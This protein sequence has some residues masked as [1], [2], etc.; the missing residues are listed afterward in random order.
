MAPAE[1][2]TVIKSGS[3]VMGAASWQGNL[4]KF[5]SKWMDMLIKSYLF[6]ALILFGY[7]IPASA[8][9]INCPS[10]FASSG[11]CL[12]GVTAGA[13][14][15]SGIGLGRVEVDATMY[16]DNYQPA[17]A[18]TFKGSC[19]STTTTSCTITGGSALDPNGG[20]VWA[21]VGDGSSDG[22]WI[23]YSSANSTTITFATSGRGYWGSTAA[24]HGNGVDLFLYIAPVYT[25]ITSATAK[26]TSGTIT[27]TACGTTY[28]SDI[29]LLTNPGTTN[30]ISVQLYALTSSGSGTLTIEP[31]T[32]C[33]SWQ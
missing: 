31:G 12:V 18:A 26:A 4:S 25:T 27:P 16:V 3:R 9:V 14:T 11:C 29:W 22:E 7:L 28:A 21:C 32:G 15:G 24:T 6:W 23:K 1:A 33:G 5:K 17:G 2:Q 8:Q 10:G 30:N 19:A 13:L 20:V